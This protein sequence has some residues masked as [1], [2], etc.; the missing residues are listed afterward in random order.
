MKHELVGKRGDSV[1]GII[2]GEV[3]LEVLDEKAE[4][5]LLSVNNRSSVT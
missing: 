1:A 2:V 5:R 4:G 3:T